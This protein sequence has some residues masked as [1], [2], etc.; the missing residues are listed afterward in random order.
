MRFLLIVT[1]ADL[2]D[3][4]PIF[5]VKPYLAYTDSHPDATGG[6]SDAVRD[7]RLAV[8][9]P[10][11]LLEKIPAEKRDALLEILAQDP[12]PSY[13]D[14]PARRYGFRFSGVDVRFTVQDDVL[15]VVEIV[16]L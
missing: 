11:E 14:D 1:G 13:Q 9:F 8:E 4:T 10:P 5:D 6:F 7:Y 16:D 3:G 2:L 12:R 15:T